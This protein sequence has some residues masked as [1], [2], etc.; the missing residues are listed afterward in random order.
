MIANI[1]TMGG[2]RQMNIE[3]QTLLRQRAQSEQMMHDQNLPDE[4]RALAKLARDNADVALSLEDALERKAERENAT[5]IQQVMIDTPTPFAPRSE[6]LA[7]IKDNTTGPDKN[8]PEIQ[9]AVAQV[10]EYLERYQD[11]S[12]NKV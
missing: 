8:L 4:V 11:K 3:R 12:S 5:M 10:R 7:F 1:A 6:L 9:E 2:H